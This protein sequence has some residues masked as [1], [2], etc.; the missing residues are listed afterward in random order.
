MR[1]VGVEGERE[2]LFI[3]AHFRGHVCRGLLADQVYGEL[4]AADLLRRWEGETRS[5]ARDLSK[6][7]GRV[8]MISVRR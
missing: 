7:L 5:V 2:Y 6:P 3:N 8:P 1:W 4:K